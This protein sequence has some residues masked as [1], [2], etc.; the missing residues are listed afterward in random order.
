MA[1]AIGIVQFNDRV[2]LALKPH[3]NT[4]FDLTKDSTT[5]NTI[6]RSGQTSVTY[7][8]PHQ[9]IVV[10]INT[11]Q[12]WSALNQNNYVNLVGIGQFSQLNMHKWAQF[13]TSI[14]MDAYN[15]FIQYLD[16]S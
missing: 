2:F 5:L 7:L 14:Q 10:S 3:E 9:V 13:N 11:S 12:Q 16:A 8:G 6:R 1:H 15:L 4:V